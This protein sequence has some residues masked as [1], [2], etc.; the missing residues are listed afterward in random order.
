MKLYMLPKSTIPFFPEGNNFSKVLAQ[1][2]PSP[3]VRKCNLNTGQASWQ[4]EIIRH[5]GNMDFTLSSSYP[6]VKR[7]P[8]SAVKRQADIS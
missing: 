2:F 5:T 4:I 7:S 1:Y 8:E 3:Y 6:S